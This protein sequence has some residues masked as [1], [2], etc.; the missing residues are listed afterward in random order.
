MEYAVLSHASSHLFPLS[1]QS[2]FPQGSSVYLNPS[3]D[4]LCK[5]FRMQYICIF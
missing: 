5:E 2:S 1:T 3:I 4:V